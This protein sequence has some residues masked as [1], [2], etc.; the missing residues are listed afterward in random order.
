MKSWAGEAQ[1]LIQYDMMAA[2]AKKEGFVQISNIFHETAENEREHGKRF[3]R[4]I[5]LGAQG[6]I[7]FEAS[8]TITSAFIESNSSLENLLFAA[9][10]EADE[11]ANV[12]PEYARIAL[13]EGYPEAAKAF[14]VIAGVELHHGQ[15][16]QLL[17]D[18][19]K[20]ETVFQKSES[21]TW[22]CINC[23]YIYEGPEAPEMCPACL[24]PKAHF[25]VETE[26]F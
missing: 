17:A 23:G 26:D 5:L 21:V 25:Q 12:Y 7:P 24:H 22:K 20:N 9:A 2:K 4:L 3:Y 15:R 8:V 16:F 6:V 10:G 1:A 19:I 13:E 11:A 14:S 18:N